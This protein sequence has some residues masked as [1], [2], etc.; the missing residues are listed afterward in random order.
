MLARLLTQRS[1]LNHA[2]NLIA[3][4]PGDVLELGLGKGRTWSHLRHLFPE[5]RIVAFD[6]GLHAPRDLTPADADLVLGDF[7]ETLPAWSGAAVLIHADIGTG[8][9]RGELGA[10]D[11]ELATFVGREAARLLAPGGAL[12]GDRDMTAAGLTLQEGP[13]IV[14]PDGAPH[15]PYKLFRKTMPA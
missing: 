9:G 3:D 12:V 4:I 10:T 2:A 5:R 13:D 11:A 6:H 14:L 1:F 15:W 7:R 8:D